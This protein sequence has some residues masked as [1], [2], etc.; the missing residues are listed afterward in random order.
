[1]LVSM[2][3]C[4]VTVVGVVAD[5]TAAFLGRGERCIVHYMYVGAKILDAGIKGMKGHGV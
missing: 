2:K 4:V 1:M 5:L 3:A